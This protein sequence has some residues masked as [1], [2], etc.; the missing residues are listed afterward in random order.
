MVGWQMG[1]LVFSFA[2]EGDT[3]GLSAVIQKEPSIRIT[4]VRSPVP[5]DNPLIT[6]ACVVTRSAISAV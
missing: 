2:A 1:K 4:D 6:S 3:N 5:K